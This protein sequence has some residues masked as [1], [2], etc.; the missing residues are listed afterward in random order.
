MRNLY[1]KFRIYD[2][3]EIQFI[4]QIIMYKISTCIKLFQIY[5]KIIREYKNN[6]YLE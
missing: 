3:L 1:T 2:I 6:N 4:H 5:T